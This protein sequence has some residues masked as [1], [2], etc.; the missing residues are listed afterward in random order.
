[1]GKFGVTHCDWLRLCT[2]VS[3]GINVTRFWKLFSHGVKREHYE[4]VIGI[5]RLLGRVSRYCFSNPFSSDSG[6]PAK[7][8]PL[9]DGLNDE[10]PVATRCHIYFTNDQY[11]TTQGIP[12]QCFS[13]A[14]Y[15]STSTLRSQHTVNKAET[16]E[17]GDFNRTLGSYCSGRLSNRK[18]CLKITLWF[19]N[20]Y[21]NVNNK[22]HYFKLLGC[23]C[24]ETHVV[25]F[26]E[27]RRC[28][29]CCPSIKFFLCLLFVSFVPNN[30]DCQG[31]QLA[32]M[33]PLTPLRL[34]KRHDL[35]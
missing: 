34:Y 9:L 32:E 15:F 16:R 3:I 19:C 26:L 1:M 31:H 23:D 12:P 33:I 2:T 14:S 10:E 4:K 13:P 30:D 24:F 11:H 25:S 8:I 7:N 20:G 28:L 29:C 22:V 21:S 5:R 6:T 18:I 35:S 27:N 17:G